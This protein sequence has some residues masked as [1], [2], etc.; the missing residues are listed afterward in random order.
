MP[1]ILRR[2]SL[3]APLRRR[4]QPQFFVRHSVAGTACIAS[5]IALWIMV[6]VPE[7]IPSLAP[8]LVLGWLSGIVIFVA[9]EMPRSLP[10]RLRFLHD[11]WVAWLYVL[12]GIVAAAA[13][14]ASLTF[15]AAYR[16]FF[17][18]DAAWVFYFPPL[19]YAARYGTAAQLK[20]FLLLAVA[21][22]AAIRLALLNLDPRAEVTTLF[23]A[24]LMCFLVY[25]AYQTMESFRVQGARVHTLHSLTQ[26]ISN[27]H[28]L[29]VRYDNFWTA[30]T[31]QRVRV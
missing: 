7:T 11:K 21:S 3:Y 24:G 25:G 15:T 22:Y 12:I 4:R 28:E 27:P 8:W 14:V 30:C 10:K 5:F 1:A 16:V 23:L 26:E 18:A 19:M 31:V 20:W 2:L 17:F 29:R 13:L 6:E 9:R